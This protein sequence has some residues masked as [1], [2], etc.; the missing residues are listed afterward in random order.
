LT[1]V[2]DSLVTSE[3]RPSLIDRLERFANGRSALALVG[4]WAFVE[5]IALPVVPDVALY[6]LVVLAPRRAV[7]LFAAVVLGA[8]AGSVVLSAIAAARHEVAMGLLLALPGIDDRLL[9]AA[10]TSVVNEGLGAFIGVGPG[11]PLKVDT[12][13]WTAAGGSP[14]L[15]AVGV[16]VNRLTRIGPGVVVMAGLGIA[17]PGLIRRYGPALAGLYA[18]FWIVLYAIYWS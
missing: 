7:P 6:A 16:V 17:A 11:T 18:A 5:A 8:L 12:V 3:P 1:F 2:H 13:A 15:L 10:A 9:S 14:L 4:G